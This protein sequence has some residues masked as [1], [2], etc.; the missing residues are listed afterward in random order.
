MPDIKLIDKYMHKDRDIET[1]AFFDL[2]T[3]MQKD[4][5]ATLKP[6]YINSIFLDK[7]ID[8]IKNINVATLETDLACKLV[9][10]LYIRIALERFLYL[11]AIK[12][13]N[14]LPII[15]DNY[16]KTRELI[17]QATKSLSDTDNSEALKASIIC[18]AFVHANSFMYEPLV[19]VPAHELL[20]Q[21]NG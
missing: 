21:Q 3:I 10:A 7:L 15:T 2:N 9:L 8:E 14:A 16:K 12:N 19:D 6:I 11:T 5:K 18:P 13:T 20:I 1:K 4:I 17:N